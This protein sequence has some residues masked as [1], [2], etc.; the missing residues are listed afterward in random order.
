M[1]SRVLSRYLTVFHLAY[2][3][4]WSIALAGDIRSDGYPPLPLA[5]ND[6]NAFVQ[7]LAAEANGSRA[8]IAE[9]LRGLGFTCTPVSKSV[10]FECVRFGCRKGFWGRGSLL[11]WSVGEDP[12]RPTRNAVAGTAVNYSWVARCLPRGDIEEAQTKFL[13][14]FTPIQ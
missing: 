14:R 6:F 13:S 3:A 4:C 9:K 12:F 11:Q 8:V 1:K 2:F 10:Q 7:K 5:M